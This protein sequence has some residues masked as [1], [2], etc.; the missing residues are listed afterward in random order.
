MQYYMLALFWPQSSCVQ[1]LADTGGGCTIPPF[2]DG[3]TLHGL[4]PEASP[5]NPQNCSGQGGLNLTELRPARG[6]LLRLWPEVF[7]DREAWQF[8]QHEWEKHGSCAL[9][10]GDVRSQLDYFV[11][12]LELGLRYDPGAALHAAGLEPRRQPHRT[13]HLLAALTSVLPRRALVRCERPAGAP[14][15]L[16]SELRVCVDR[17]WQPAHCYPADGSAIRQ[18]GCDADTVLY[19]PIRH[20]TVP[21]WPDW[22]PTKGDV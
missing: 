7:A 17:H 20:E 18:H 15:P 11:R 13:A 10:A 6:A 8:W 3:W 14:L 2:I 1:H 22:L 16:L 5:N 9:A 12:A 21:R 4:W 19:P